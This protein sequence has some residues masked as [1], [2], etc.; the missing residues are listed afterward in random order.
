MSTQEQN[1][2]RMARKFTGDQIGAHYLRSKKKWSAHTTW[3]AYDLY[4]LGDTEMEAV[5]LLVIKHRNFLGLSGD[6]IIAI[7]SGREAGLAHVRKTQRHE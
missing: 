4:E 3:K 5:M 7:I 6:D 1:T 2:P